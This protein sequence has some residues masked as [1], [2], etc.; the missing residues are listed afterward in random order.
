MKYSIYLCL[1]VSV[2]AD[3]SECED[4]TP[5]CA[6]PYLTDDPEAVNEDEATVCVAATDDPQ[7]SVADET[8]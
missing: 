7:C 1:I 6:T 4:A 2:S 3:C 5:V 8:N